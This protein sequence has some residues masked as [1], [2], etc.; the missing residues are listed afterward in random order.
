ME[1]RNRNSFGIQRV[2]FITII[3]LLMM[4]LVQRFYSDKQM[5]IPRG[6]WDKLYLVLDQIEK[7][8]VD[9][10]DAKEIVEKS[11]PFILEELDPHSVYLPPMELQRADEALEGSF[12]GI[13]ITFNVPNDTAVVSTVISGGPSERAGLLSGDRLVEV[14]GVTVA[15]VKMNQDSIVKHLRGPRGSKV[16]I[17]VQRLGLSDLIPVS[18]IRDKIAEKSVDVSYMLD[19]QIG[20]IKLSK[21]T[22]TSYEEALRALGELTKQGMTKLI[23]DLRDNSG[24]YMEPAL[25]I[26]NEFLDKGQLIMYQEGANRPRQDYFAK[27]QGLASGIPL[28]VLINEASASSSEIL[29]GALQDNDRAVIVGRRSYGKGLVQEPIYFSDRSGMRLTVGRYFTPTGRCLQRPYDNG[30]DSYRYD[31]WER[32]RHG[33][34]THADSIPK[35]D[36][37]KYQTPK[38]KIVYGGGGIIPDLFVPIDTTANDFLWQAER[39]GMMFRFSSQFAD[40]HRAEI[41]EIKEMNALNNLFGRVDLGKAFL[42]YAA[43]QGLT[44]KPG[45]W[46]AGNVRILNLIEAYI[47]RSTPM[48]D[49]AFYQII[50]KLDRELRVAAGEL[51]AD[52]I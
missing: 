48:E 52:K 7:N 37:L 10:V 2:Y 31:I 36:S 20:Y 11:L 6:E 5:P 18:I 4:L 22:R 28:A 33:E 26:A 9:D 42:A 12:D 41:R 16:T 51:R 21:F 1:K 24:G 44:P 43:G 47:G 35:I 29:A 49:Q 38:G 23:F 32:Y 46:E 3:I 13:G 39:R 17:Q 45:E 19:N 50:G 30:R 34:L 14:N 27:T 15:G 40:N 25:R 8:Y